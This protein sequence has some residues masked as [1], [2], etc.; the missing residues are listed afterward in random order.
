MDSQLL[1]YFKTKSKLAYSGIAI[2]SWYCILASNANAQTPSTESAAALTEHRDNPATPTQLSS[3][4]KRAVTDE[5]GE[6]GGDNPAADPQVAQITTPITNIVLPTIL[7]PVL[8][9]N[10]LPPSAPIVPIK[11]IFTQDLIPPPNNTPAVPSDNTPIPPKLESTRDPRFIIPPKELDPNVVDPFSNQFILNGNKVSHRT[12]T[13][14]TAGYE[15]GPFRNS[16]LSF[17]IYKLIGAKNTQSVTADRVVRVNSQLEVVGLRTVAQNQEINVSI[18]KPQTLL[19]FRQQIS[20]EGDCLNGVG[21]CTYL[22]G[23]KI[24]D[25]VIDPLKL[26]PRGALI[27]SQFGDR[28]S[29]ASLAAIREPGF[30]GGANGANGANYG[31]DLYIPAVGLISPPAGTVTP[32]TGE[33]QEKI[34]NGIAVNATRMNQNFAT[35]GTESTLARTVRSLNYINGDRNQVV[36]ALVNAAGQILPEFQPSIAPGKPGARIVVNPN[37]YRAANSVRI[38]DNSQTVYQAGTG[39]AP[40]YGS[41]PK[42]PPE[43]KHLALWVGLSPVVEREF[44]RDYHYITLR[45]PRIVASGGGEG[46]TLPV[47]INLNG[48]GFN[49]G[50]LRNAYGQG[51][52]TVYNRD[53]KRVDVE[54]IRQRTDYYPHISLTGAN[55]T[56]NT[57]WRYF[58]GAIV[59][60]GF[61]PKTT[62][63]IKPYLGTDYSVVNQR[64]LSFS[65]GGVGYLNPDPEYYSQLFTSATQSIALGSNSR[66]SL[67]LGVNA[68]YIVD[69]AITI[70]SL[71]IRSAQSFVSAGLGVNLGD[72]SVGGTQ[73]IGNLLPESVQSKTI[74]NVGWKITDRLKVGGFVTAFDRNVSKNPFGASL[75][76][77]LDPSSNSTLYLGW[78]AAEIDFRR[79]LGPTANTYKD[80]TV[81]VSLRY[82]F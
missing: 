76:F 36:N 28:I 35:N 48:F 24:D 73:F 21:I 42:V 39:S 22:P 32:L 1:T 6:D 50:G 63:N 79:T 7:S 65:V 25:S 45:E 18:S 51:Y 59:N 33:R 27:T 52:V 67:V 60:A 68:N 2:A 44:G 56:E 74:F 4:T 49:S 77:D 20:L 70:Q 5:E 46:G 14:A 75:G 19:G 57:L 26:Q 72:V 80:N 43:A 82:G 78:N 40:S 71:P 61:Q 8:L 13:V 58:T 31:I 9:P 38:P 66:N 64:G 41:D 34:S 47:D 12:S 16:D 15:A 53:V 10:L 54:T 69:G 37:L 3:T 11:S 29:P 55:L 81:S 17:D 23:I 62:S 30:Q